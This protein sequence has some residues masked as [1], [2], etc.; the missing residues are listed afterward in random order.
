MASSMSVAAISELAEECVSAERERAAHLTRKLEVAAQEKREMSHRAMLLDGKLAGSEDRCQEYEAMLSAATEYVKE[1]EFE[2]AN[3]REQVMQA[4]HSVRVMQVL[5]SKDEEMHERRKEDVVDLKSRLKKAKEK[6]AELEPLASSSPIAIRATAALKELREKC[7]GSQE[8]MS[9]MRMQVAKLKS[10]LEMANY[11]GENILIE[12]KQRGEALEAERRARNGAEEKERELARNAEE[13]RSTISSLKTKVAKQ[14][15][16][17]KSA[18]E[19]F[20]ARLKESQIQYDARLATEREQVVKEYALKATA[21][22]QNAEDAE[23]AFRSKYEVFLKRTVEKLKSQHD[24]HIKDQ[25]NENEKLR[26]LLNHQ[27]EDIEGSHIHVNQ[28]KRALAAGVAKERLAFETEVLRLK[29]EHMN[30][31]AK[32]ERTL[33]ASFDASR[34][35]SE[36][37]MKEIEI[38]CNESKDRQQRLQTLLSEQVETAERLNNALEAARVEISALKTHSSE[39]EAYVTSLKLQLLDAQKKCASQGERLKGAFEKEKSTSVDYENEVCILNAKLSA[40]EADLDRIHE[41]YEGSQSRLAAQLR[42]EIESRMQAEARVK[43]SETTIARM[44]SDVD[45]VVENSKKRSKEILERCHDAE[46]KCSALESELGVLRK[47]LVEKSAR[48]EGCEKQLDDAR[49]RMLDLEDSNTSLE[50]EAVHIEGNR[51]AA[52]LLEASL[53]KTVRD[54]TLEA[55]A[56]RAKAK[57][58]M[59][60]MSLMARD[61]VRERHA[62][63]VR[64]GVD[65]G[66]FLF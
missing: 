45:R 49:E 11:K 36:L 5:R 62:S 61:V 6:V 22:M 63:P 28:H 59:E 65:R 55:E 34:E 64:Q 12:C 48:L 1:L 66:R 53:R 27:L 37:E 32:L 58:L 35:K 9:S 24:R 44:K 21:E 33:K 31:T 29:E 23:K 25:R 42:D 10:Q 14:E 30:A 52:S 43:E 50:R 7:E 4:E 41:K 17:F 16:D 2:N 40:R 54:K 46:V 38:S 13:L 3:M 20:E 18:Q 39:R 8:Q 57:E 26:R 19:F 51:R 47:S 15:R 56:E 60:K